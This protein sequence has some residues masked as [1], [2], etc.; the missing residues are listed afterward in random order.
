MNTKMWRNFFHDLE[1]QEPKYDRNLSLIGE[2]LFKDLDLTYLT[3][4]EIKLLMEGRKENVMKK[5][6]DL[7]DEESLDTIIEFDEQYKY[8]HLMWMAKV[9]SQYPE[10]EQQMKIDDL[11]AAISDFVR[12]SKAL[13]RKDIN[14]YKNIEDL[15][16]AVQTDV[17]E[18][19]IAKAKKKR[20][21]DKQAQEFINTG[22]GSVIY[23]DER[24]F[25]VR[26][27]SREASCYF[28][29]KTRWCIAQTGNSYFNSYTQGEGRVFYFIKD[30]T[31]KNEA[32]NYKMAIE[33]SQGSG[34]DLV[35]NNVWDRHDEQYQIEST[36][37]FD[38]IT[39]LHEDFEMPED[40]AEVIASEIEEHA[41]ANPPESPLADLQQKIDNG[42][43]DSGYV[44]VSAYYEDYDEQPYM[45]IHAD[46]RIEY[47][48]KN[49]DLIRMLE[50]GEVEIDDAEENI[51][52]ALEDSG[53]LK[54]ALDADVDIGASKYWWPNTYDYGDE[55]IQVRIAR[56]PAH[57]T[58]KDN[59]FPW[60]IIIELN[61]FTDPDNGGTYYG[62]QLQDAE[63]FCE[64]MKEEWGERNELDIMEVLEKHLLRYIPEFAKSQSQA[65][66]S[67]KS[68]FTSGKHDLNDNVYYTI[69]DESEEDS[70]LNLHIDFT[71]ALSDNYF[72]YR[73]YRGEEI[74]NTQGNK[75]IRAKSSKIEAQRLLGFDMNQGRV[76]HNLE[77]A[78]TNIY[79]KAREYGSRQLKLD[80]GAEW[81]ETFEDE[82]VFPETPASVGKPVIKLVT[83]TTQGLVPEYANITIQYNIYIPFHRSEAELS[84]IMNFFNFIKTNYDDIRSYVYKYM[85]Q[86]YSFRA[87]DGEP[88]LKESLLDEILESHLFLREL[89]EE[90]ELFEKKKRK[91]RK[92]KKKKKGKKDACYHKVRARYD[93]WPSAYASGALVKCR[94]VGAANWGNKSKKT[95]EDIEKDI[96]LDLEFLQEVEELVA[97]DEKKKK[98]K[99]KRKLTSKPSSER[100]LRDWFGR[101]G[102]KGSKK[103]WV[104]CNAPD[105]KGGYKSCGRSSGEKRKRYPACR[106]TPGACK[107]MKGSKGK[108]WGKKGSK[109]K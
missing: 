38:L 79:N 63:Q 32:F 84:V 108:S 85:K 18:P 81:A 25:V 23:E 17:I 30:D 47:T 46:C 109:K 13:K 99:K 8:K 24:Y 89:D 26:P 87:T 78:I 107:K 82:M 2:D 101:R 39:T 72:K 54:E 42:E 35:Y 97:L 94:K 55:A 27:D 106:P 75:V 86:D 98:R 20:A 68:E 4:S 11:V 69:D 50:E 71:F 102:A 43:Y 51:R 19:R 34:E 52:E 95:N 80:F 74:T 96:E 37:L 92:K 62:S 22:Q 58:G 105:G 77:S 103:G 6:R 56:P 15:L 67:L 14:S 76:T 60:S 29:S 83:P 36:D 61:G 65:F 49:P 64:Y 57:R 66:Q 48:I 100:S 104:D 73:L 59:Q 33:M 45:S 88:M 21:G 12:Y 70:D 9:L 7:I 44:S 5:Y 93:V 53:E 28:G 1:K 10:D 91:K 41:M 31:K 16:G 3:E 90:L 40:K